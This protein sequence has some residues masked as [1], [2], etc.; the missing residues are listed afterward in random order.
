MFNTGLLSLGLVDV[1]HQDTLVLEDVTLNLEVERVIHVL[2]NLSSLTVLTEHTTEDAHATHPDDVRGHTTF[3][4][5]TALTNTRVATFALSLGH[6]TNAETRV[7][8]LGLLDDQSIL[9]ELANS[10]A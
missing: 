6:A 4:G 8:G 10:L 5:T 2:I 7:D 3:T 1:L 9:D